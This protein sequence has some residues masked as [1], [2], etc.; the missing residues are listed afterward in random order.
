MTALVSLLVVAAMVVARERR[1]APPPNGGWP[2]TFESLHGLGMFAVAC[3]IVAAL[4]A[5]DAEPVDA[6]VSVRSDTTTDP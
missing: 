3:V 5:D 1:S 4:T 2:S 6:A